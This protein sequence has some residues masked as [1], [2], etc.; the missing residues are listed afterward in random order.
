MEKQSKKHLFVMYAIVLCMSVL[1]IVLMFSLSNKAED[2]ERLQGLRAI[3]NVDS[4]LNNAQNFQ[5][6]NLTQ[7]ITLEFN[8][9]YKR[10]SGRF[11]VLNDR[12]H[13]LY[14]TDYVFFFGYQVSDWDWCAEVIDADLGIIA[15]RAPPVQWMNEDSYIDLQEGTSID[16]LFY[17]DLS[18]DVERDVRDQMKQRIEQIAQAYLSEAVLQQSIE[19]SLSYFL[20]QSINDAHEGQP[21]SA[22]RLRE[23]CS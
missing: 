9:L 21:V 16:S 2:L 15:L 14:S 6:A 8:Q 22:I 23:S 10:P 17:T 1:S 5:F 13:Q 18:S 11:G 20:V 3:P 7:S 19:R 4:A 12:V